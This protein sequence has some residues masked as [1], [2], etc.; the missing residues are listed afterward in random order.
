MSIVWTNRDLKFLHHEYIREYDIRSA[1]TSLMSYYGLMPD[2]DIEKIA[3]MDRDEREITVG[4][5]M[6]KSPEFSRG[7]EKAF[8]DIVEEFISVNG[9]DRDND[10]ISI[11]K[12]AVFVRNRHVKQTRF[13]ESV[14]FRPKGEYGGFIQIPG[15]E[16]YWKTG[17]RG[18]DVKG[19]SDDLLPLHK[20]GVL[21]LMRSIFKE[22]NSTLDLWRFLKEYASCYKRKDLPFAAYRQ[23]DNSSKFLVHMMNQDIL[24]DNINEGMLEYLDISFNYLNVYLECLKVVLER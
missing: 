9:L 5:L 24:M 3:A 15:F 4:K 12:D 10:I 18:F 6:R 7:L 2:K 14:Q 19:I 16:F 1:N 8:T 22:S 21:D 13:G 11:K 17:D 20:E 23:F